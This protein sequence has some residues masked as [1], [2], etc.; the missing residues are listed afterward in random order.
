[1]SGEGSGYWVGMA[2]DRTIASRLTSGSEELLAAFDG[3]VVS[4]Q[5]IQ[6]HR[7]PADGR[8]RPG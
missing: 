6:Q 7:D 4:V 1:M 3:H 2:L 5:L 8:G